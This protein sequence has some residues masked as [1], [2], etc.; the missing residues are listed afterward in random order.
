YEL[1]VIR[2]LTANTMCNPGGYEHHRT[3]TDPFSLITASSNTLTAAEVV[4]VLGVVMDMLLDVPPGRVARDPE[5]EEAA[6]LVRS[7]KVLGER[8]NVSGRLL[9]LLS[10]LVQK[11]LLL[12]RARRIG[13]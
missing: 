11:Q 12:P 10:A 1:Q 8:I 9:P 2:P 13:Y 3:G 6:P 4:D 5:V 7:H